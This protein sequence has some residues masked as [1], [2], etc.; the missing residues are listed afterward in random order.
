VCRRFKSVLRYHQETLINQ[1]FLALWPAPCRPFSCRVMS[2]PRPLIYNGFQRPS[3]APRDTNATRR[4]SC[5]K[6]FRPVSIGS[7]SKYQEPW[8]IGLDGYPTDRR[9]PCYRA[10][11]R[12]PQQF[13]AEVL[14][15]LERDGGLT[16]LLDA[17]AWCRRHQLPLP[18]WAAATV[19][20]LLKAPDRLAKMIGADRRYRIHRTRWDMVAELRDRREELVRSPAHLEPTLPAAFENASEALG[21]TE[22]A[23]APDTI[24]KS[25]QRVERRFRKRRR[26]H[27]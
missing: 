13:H 14:G 11:S 19:L 2:H 7:M 17:I 9:H 25:W 12:T 6:A 27:F 21:G 23:G 16:A 10:R 20:Q 22:A 5:C 8:E 3:A 15:A 26:D 1:A 4:D 24:K 18:D